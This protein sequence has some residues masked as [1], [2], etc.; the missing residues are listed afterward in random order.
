MF[1]R[2]LIVRIR[3]IPGNRDSSGVSFRILVTYRHRRSAMDNMLSQSPT[4]A[5]RPVSHS[6]G[7]SVWPDIAL[8]GVALIWGINMPLMKTGLEQLDPYV[9]NAL[10]LIISAVCLG[11]FA[12]REWRSGIRP[13][14]EIT[15]GKIAVFSILISGLYQVSF[16]MGMARTTAGNT[17][18]ILAT[19]PAWTALLASIFI[20]ERLSRTAWFGLLLAL[21][22]TVVVAAQKGDLSGGQKHLTG[23]LIILGSALAWATGTVYSRPLLKSI[24]PMQLS[25]SAALLALPVHLLIAAPYYADNVQHLGSV[26][27]WLILAWAGVLSSGL[28]L[29][30]WNFGVR[31]AGAS[32]AAVVQN[33]VPLIAIAT[34]WLTRGESATNPQIV[35]GSAILCGLIIMR[36]SR[37]TLNGKETESIQRPATTD[38]PT[39]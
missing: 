33:L 9:F 21:C 23:N 34:A 35:G 37:N 3:D 32:H 27:L 25:A 6:S 39:A 29:P 16:L 20:G 36:L 11:L 18:L 26:N 19:I 8:V 10:R 1:G 15:I 14:S 12:L 5:A 31:Q 7:K 13:G 38:K 24:S 30:M 4:T 28:S 22:G 2:Q 17:A